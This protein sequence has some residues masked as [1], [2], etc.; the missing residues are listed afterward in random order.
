VYDSPNGEPQSAY[1]VRGQIVAISDCVTDEN[2]V[3]WVEI[4]WGENDSFRGWLELERL[5]NIQGSL[6]CR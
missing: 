1:V 2:N 6:Y 4:V 3:S 5:D